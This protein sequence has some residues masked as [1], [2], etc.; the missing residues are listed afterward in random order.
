[1]RVISL[2]ALSEF[3]EKHPDAKS[4]LISWH[5]NAKAARWETPADVINTYRKADVVG[6]IMLVSDIC[7]GAYRLVVSAN[8][9][10]QI[11]YVYGVYTHAEY[12]RLDL[13]AIAEEFRRRYHSS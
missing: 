12:D 8:Y 1:M 4:P 2:K 6:G 9:R 13:P 10:T 3:W 11:L 5:L 7:K